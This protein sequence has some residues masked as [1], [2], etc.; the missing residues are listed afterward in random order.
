MY[1]FTDDV[2]VCLS[3]KIIPRLSG[4]PYRNLSWY[5]S[6]QGTDKS[7]ILDREVVSTHVTLK[8]HHIRVHLR[9]KN[10]IPFLW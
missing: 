9:F 1:G 4:E 8:S 5:T 10:R 2:S 3:R 6:E 7:I